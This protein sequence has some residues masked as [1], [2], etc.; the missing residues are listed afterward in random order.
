MT[1]PA[2][3][4]TARTAEC[5]LGRVGPALAQT[6][7]REQ[8]RCGICQYLSPTKDN[9]EAHWRTECRLKA[10]WELG[11]VGLALARVIE[12]MNHKQFS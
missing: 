11:R 3:L 6:G 10:E 5:E 12:D 7:K 9:L 8:L 1:H 4:A 2:G